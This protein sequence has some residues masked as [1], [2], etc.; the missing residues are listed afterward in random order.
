MINMNKSALS[1]VVPFQ[2][3]TFFIFFLLVEPNQNPSYRNGSLHEGPALQRGIP[4]GQAV[5]PLQGVSIICISK[6]SFV[7]WNVNLL[8]CRHA[9][10]TAS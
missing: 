7:S 8:T 1:L 9:D 5:S 6:H 10:V 3:N 2:K 4:G